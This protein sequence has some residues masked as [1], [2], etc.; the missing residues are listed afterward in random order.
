MPLSLAD[1]VPHLAERLETSRSLSE[2]SAVDLLHLRISRSCVELLV[3]VEQALAARER[4]IEPPQ[5]EIVAPAFHE[6]G[7][8]LARNHRVEQRQVLVDELLLQADRVRRDDDLRR[9]RRLELSA[10][11][12]AEPSLLSFALRRRQNRRHKIR[13]A[14]ADARARFG[15]KM[16]LRRDRPRDRVRHLQLLRPMLVIRQPRRNAAIRAK[17]IGGGELPFRQRSR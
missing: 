12:V 16:P 13:K 9:T 7:G 6:H 8:E 10:S 14:L 17:N 1:F 15:H 4:E 2:P 5:A 3:V 11:P